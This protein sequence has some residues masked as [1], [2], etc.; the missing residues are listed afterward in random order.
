MIIRPRSSMLLR[1]S[2]VSLRRELLGPL[3]ASMRCRM[4]RRVATVLSFRVL[5]V[6]ITASPLTIR[7]F[8]HILRGFLE[9]T[10]QVSVLVL[11]FFS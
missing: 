7:V 11:V 2:A 9:D 4:S 6:R 5:C 1:H 8:N 10:S 3:I